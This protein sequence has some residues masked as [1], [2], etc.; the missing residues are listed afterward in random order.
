MLESD[1]MLMT[2]I[3]YGNFQYMARQEFIGI[4]KNLILGAPYLEAY[5]DQSAGTPKREPGECRLLIDDNSIGILP[6]PEAHPYFSRV[7]KIGSR[8]YF[9]WMRDTAEEIDAFMV[10]YKDAY[11]LKYSGMLKALKPTPR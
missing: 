11:N 9:Y 10:Q 7:R 1:L 3:A 2:S 5:L 4:E 6:L 8:W